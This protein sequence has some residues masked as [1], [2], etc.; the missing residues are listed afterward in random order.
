M[1][2]SPPLPPSP[3]EGPP[4]GT[5][6]SRRKATHPFPPS[7]ALTQVLA[8]SMNIRRYSFSSLSLVAGSFVVGTICASPNATHSRKQQKEPRHEGEAQHSSFDSKSCSS[9]DA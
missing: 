9:V 4:R 2:T 6:F 7:P 8:S 5:K 3:P 1:M